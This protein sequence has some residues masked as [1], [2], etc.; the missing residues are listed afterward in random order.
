MPYQFHK[1]RNKYHAQK[2]SYFGVT[3]DSKLE[4][5]RSVFLMDAVRQG[6]IRNV[7]R[8]VRYELIPKQ[9]YEEVVQLKTK[10]KTVTKVAERECDYVADFVYE[11]RMPDNTWQVVVEDT[12]S[13]VTRTADYRIKKKLMLWRHGIRLREVQRATEE[14]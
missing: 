2:Q 9:T 1:G 4:G 3:F 10:T 14:I 13:P 8:Q 12:K 5:A 6:K 11:K 7:R